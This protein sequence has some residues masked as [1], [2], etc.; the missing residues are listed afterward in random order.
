MSEEPEKTETADNIARM[1]NDLRRVAEFLVGEGFMKWSLVLLNI[2][3]SIAD[4]ASYR[5][6][7]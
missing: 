3:Q 7:P 1:R 6:L 5:R 2:E 4:P